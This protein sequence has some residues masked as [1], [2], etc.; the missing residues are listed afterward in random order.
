MKDNENK[1]VGLII[2]V[3][4]LVVGGYLLGNLD[5]TSN[6]ASEDVVEVVVSDNETKKGEI[7][8]VLEILS[9]LH[10]VSL[11]NTPESDTVS[12]FIYNETKEA[13]DD[14]NRLEKISYRIENLKKSNTEIVSLSGL[15]LQ[16][17]TLTLVDS[18]SVWRDYLRTVDE[19]ADMSEYQYQSALLQSSI[20]DSYLTMI[21]GMNLFP[22][23]LVEFA[24]EEEEG[25]INKELETHFRSEID[26]LFTDHII[27]NNTFYEETGL[28]YST[29]ILIEGYIELL[30]PSN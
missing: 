11:D 28:R 24:E 27:D 26:R 3:A 16:G 25:T 15:L 10:F 19:N 30:D 4:V 9:T 17:V 23:I 7:S 1:K 18:M 13:M 20:K 21:E 2:I 29:I 22:V 8:E 6:K 12:L 5:K 14:I